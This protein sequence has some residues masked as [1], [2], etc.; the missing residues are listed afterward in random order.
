MRWPRRRGVDL[1]G[2]AAPDPY[3]AVLPVIDD[4]ELARC[5]AT[6]EPLP[7]GIGPDYNERIVEYPWAL[8]HPLGARVL[9]AGSTFNHSSLL[10]RLLPRIA[11]LTIVTLAPEG[12][13]F[14]ER[15]IEYVYADLRC[16]PFRDDSFDTVVS[17][18]TLEHV[19]MDNSRY[20][21]PTADGDPV[22]AARRALSELRRV[23]AP[24]GLLLL[25]VPYGRAEDH[26]WFR[27]FDA[28]ALDELLGD[29]P[30]RMTTFRLGPTGWQAVS[31]ADAADASYGR[32][33]PAAAAVA[34]LRID[35]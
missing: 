24:G 2:P 16:L 25:T 17:I 19:G 31:A 23:V 12:P 10:D 11:R 35:G 22:T 21:G 7:E 20:G 5:F 26:G 6:G 1:P 29:S 32:V 28:T 27:Q 8:A 9:D 34:C 4:S 15:G 3:A 18:S 14:A 33:A 13:S 30:R